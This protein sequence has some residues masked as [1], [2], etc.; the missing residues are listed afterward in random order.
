LCAKVKWVSSHNNEPT[1]S[2]YVVLLLVVM[3]LMVMLWCSIPHVF[4][5]LILAFCSCLNYNRLIFFNGYSMWSMGTMV[6]S[7]GCHNSQWWVPTMVICI[8]PR[9]CRCFLFIIFVVFSNLCL[10]FW[11]LCSLCFCVWTFGHDMLHGLILV[12]NSWS[13]CLGVLTLVLNSLSS[14]FC[15]STLVFLPWSSCYL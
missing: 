8:F 11:L 4:G 1:L 2:M 10:N 14:F 7:N 13:S 9:V 12:F 5:A 15:G 6:D 3:F